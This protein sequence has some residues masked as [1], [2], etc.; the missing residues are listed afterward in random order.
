MSDD[1]A[2]NQY[3]HQYCH[4]QYNIGV[5]HTYKG[6]KATFSQQ[7][8]LNFCCMMGVYVTG[9]A[10][11]FCILLIF[12]ENVQIKMILTKNHLNIQY[13]LLRDE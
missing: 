7:M 10:E 4:H 11:T 13:L 12:V 9:F 8:S 6:N 3:G 5:Q 2:T 1:T